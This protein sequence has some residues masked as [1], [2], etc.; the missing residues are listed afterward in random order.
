MGVIV[1]A[2]G[3]GTN[4][5]ALLIE[6]VNRGMK[7]DLIIFSDTGAERPETYS[8]IDLFSQWLVDNNM[9]PITIVHPNYTL[10]SD[11]LRRKRLPALA[12][13][14]KTCSLQFKR[15][16]QEKFMNNI[17]AAKMLWKS[18]GKVIKLM[19]YDAGEKGRALGKSG[20]EKYDCHYPLID[21]DIWRDDCLEIIHDA[22]LPQPGKSSCFFCPS[23]KKREIMALVKDH[24]DL[25]QR[26][27]V[28]EE[29]A[30]LLTVKGL[31]RDWAWRDLIRYEE[32]QGNMFGKCM[33]W[34]E[35]NAPCEC[36][37]G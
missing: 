22:G 29:N 13:G 17:P 31:G 18:G 24:P 12:Y 10:E 21:W 25:L 27:L 32:G 36:Y 19:G 26:A 20:D 35:T 16:P 5:T 37:D 15:Q 3:G 2:Y 34:Y 14:F 11:C 4:S 8:F 30:D 6:Y 33:T 23:M 7:V 9:P 28:I 1:A